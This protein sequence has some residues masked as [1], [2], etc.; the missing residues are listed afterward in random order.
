MRVTIAYLV[1]MITATAVALALVAG[2]SNLAGPVAS[3][4]DSHMPKAALP[5]SPVISPGRLLQGSGPD[6][7]LVTEEGTRWRFAD[8]QTVQ[9]FGFS[10]ADVTPVGDAML[11]DVPLVGPLSRLLGDRHGN[12]Y[13]M[14]Q[15]RRWAVDRWQQPVA[16]AGLP[17]TLLEPD[18]QKL[19]PPPVRLEAGMVLK[20]GPAL[21]YFQHD[22]IVPIPAEVDLGDPLLIDVPAGAAAAYPTRQYLEQANIAL[23]GSAPLVQIYAG[24]GSTFSV[25]GVVHRDD[26]TL[27]AQAQSTD[28]QWLRVTHAGQPAWLPR[29]AVVGDLALQL[30]PVAA[31]TEGSG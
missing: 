19:L 26:T 28:G 17:V 31:E 21:Y 13:W 20:Q 24:P 29:A 30:L 25:T 4:A 9:A 16:Q 8:S 1:L 6:I 12:L 23:V 11:A 18:L 2:F 7:Y 27:V 5:A 22:A 14:A 3:R 15:G 10:M